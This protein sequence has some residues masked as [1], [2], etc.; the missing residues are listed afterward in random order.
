MKKFI[1]PA[2]RVATAIGLLYIIWS[3]RG[4]IND[5]K[6]KTTQYDSLK[7]ECDSLKGE[8]FTQEIQVGRYEVIMDNLETELSPDCKKTLNEVLSQVE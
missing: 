7:N 8:I 2:L 3:Q 4:Q 5:L 1:T 6:M